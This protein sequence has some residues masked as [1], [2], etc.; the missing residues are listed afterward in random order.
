M[1][2]ISP[3]VSGQ[4]ADQLLLAGATVLCAYLAWHHVQLLLAPVPLDVFEN[5]MP[6]I[7]G[8]I[9]GGGNPYS[10]ENQPLYTSVYPPLYNLLTAPLTLLFGNGLLLHRL[11]TGAF[12]LG[13]C[14]LCYRAVT[15]AGAGAAYALSGAALLYAALLYFSTP[16][17]SASSTGVFLYLLT[18]LTPWWAGFTTRSLLLSAV[19]AVLAFYAKQYFLAAPAFLALYLLF[20]RSRRD[21]MVYATA[22]GCLLVS[23]IVVVQLTS[24]YYFDNTVFAVRAATGVFRKPGHLVEQL[25]DYL[26]IYAPLLVALLVA[27]LR[28]RKV[29][30]RQP[31]F[32]WFCLALATL[33]IVLSLGQ[34]RGNHLSYLFQLMSPL[35]L[36]AALPVL[37]HQ[38]RGRWLATVLVLMTAVQAARQLPANLWVDEAP[39]QRVERAIADAAEVYADPL[40]LHQLSRQDK[41]VHQGPLTEWFHF[42]LLKP[43]ALVRDD[44]RLRVRTMTDTHIARVN[45]AIEQQR[46]DLVVLRKG[47]FGVIGAAREGFPFE[48]GDGQA[49]FRDNYR[50]DEELTVSLPPRRGGGNQ[51]IQLWRPRQQAPAPGNV[52]R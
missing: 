43:A 3:P 31:G 19:C 15:R 40:F 18:L 23:S 52:V 30:W 13:S 35:L 24:P 37:A 25:V 2:D 32:P 7:T 45:D 47:R 22:V 27:W 8:L 6:F 26:A 50:L 28:G 17:A 9:A 4:R 11:V 34:S 46:Y 33:V 39:W 14:A 16:V 10:F 20:Y 44:P 1:T 49:A 51:V 36:V 29:D 41:T 12:I 42:A 38:E 21:A 5:A 48:P